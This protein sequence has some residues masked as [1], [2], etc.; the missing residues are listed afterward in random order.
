MESSQVEMKVWFYG[1][2]CK[3]DNIDVL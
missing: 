3:K 1:M 2:S